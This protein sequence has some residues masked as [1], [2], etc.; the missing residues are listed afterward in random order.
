MLIVRELSHQ[1][2]AL[3][4]V[5]EGCTNDTL[6]IGNLEVDGEHGLVDL[7]LLI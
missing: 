1:E 6:R 7:T 2:E 5:D 4:Q 3:M